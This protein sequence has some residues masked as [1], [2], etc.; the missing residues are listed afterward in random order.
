[1][2]R[3]LR[4]VA[5]TLLMVLPGVAAAQSCRQSLVLGLDVSGSVD[6]REYRQQLDGLAGAL[7]SAPVRAA[8]LQAPGAPVALAVFEWSGR[9]AQRLVADWALIDSAAALD[10]FTAILRSTARQPMPPTTALGEAM[11]H[12]AGMSATGPACA[13]RTLDISG[14]G[15]SNDG[16][17]PE[18][19]TGDPL[20]AGVIVNALVIGAGGRESR[21]LEAY[22]QARVRHGPGAFVELAQGFDDYRRAMELK[23]LRELQGLSLSSLP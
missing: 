6:D 12:G 7:D 16:P 9:A 21:D 22:F 2:R 10:R 3:W 20:L 8:L 11:R 1:M 4:A 23:L 15:R 13:T 18:D 5:V 14:D 19:V 17:R